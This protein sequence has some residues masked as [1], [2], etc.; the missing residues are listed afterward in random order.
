M[1]F[2]K[3]SLGSVRPRVLAPAIACRSSLWAPDLRRRNLREVRRLLPAG[4]CRSQ[5][6]G[7]REDQA[8][9][10]CISCGHIDHV[11]INAAINIRWRVNSMFL[12]VEGLHQQSREASTG[13]DLTVSENSWP[14]GW[15]IY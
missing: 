12:D 7:I 2:V 8:R 5:E 3:A 9:F 1:S 15:G 13:R 14:S 6:S 10:T 4:F 11:D